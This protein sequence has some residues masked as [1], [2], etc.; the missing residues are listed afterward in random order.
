MLWPR[1]FVR[2][3]DLS[4]LWLFLVQLGQGCRPLPQTRRV[5]TVP[6]SAGEH[7]LRQD[8][9]GGTPWGCSSHRAPQPHP[10]QVGPWRVRP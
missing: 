2:W 8:L 1:V 4:E 10:L 5:W 3:T 6:H 9:M 7:S